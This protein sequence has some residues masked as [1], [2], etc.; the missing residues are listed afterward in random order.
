MGEARIKR[1]KM[2]P[3]EQSKL[4]FP[5][6]MM[7][8]KAIHQMGDISNDTPDICVITE[9]GLNNYIGHW[10]T[11]FGFLSFCTGK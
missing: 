5:C 6:Y 2:K 10:V 4:Q 7:A 1:L 3:K 8:T 11:G 9:E